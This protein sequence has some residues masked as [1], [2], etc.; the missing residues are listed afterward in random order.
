[1]KANPER[2]REL[3]KAGYQRNADAIRERKRDEHYVRKYGLS[4]EDRDAMLAAQGGLCAI[5]GCEPNPNH[6]GGRLHIDHCHA[7][8]TIRG[9]LCSNCNTLLGLADDDPARL[10]AAAKYLKKHKT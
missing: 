2:A 4:R 10:M 9:L 8:G 5:C 6:R 3:A 1:M 7:T